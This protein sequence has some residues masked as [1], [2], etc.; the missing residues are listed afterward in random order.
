MI[1]QIREQVRRQVRLLQCKRLASSRPHADNL[2]HLLGAGQ[3]K[4]LRDVRFGV[5]Q[6]RTY[7]SRTRSYV[8]SPHLL[9]EPRQSGEID[10]DTRFTDEVAARSTAA[11]FDPSVLLQRAECLSQGHPTHPEGG[12]QPLLGRQ[13]VVSPELSSDDS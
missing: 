3:L 2:E 5:D 4:A 10:L 12:R 11:S 13:P 1:E 6:P 9:G 8:G 7:D